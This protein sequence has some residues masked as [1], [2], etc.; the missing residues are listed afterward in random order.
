MSATAVAIPGASGALAPTT[1]NNITYYGFSARET[2]GTT[3][4]V[5]RVRDGGV[6]GGLILDTVKLAPGES[7]R[8]Y[9]TQGLNA[10]GG[11]YFELVSGALEGSIRYG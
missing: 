5:F 2:T 7:A 3:A 11:L 8:E 10:R 4:A 6:V 1:G 9:Y